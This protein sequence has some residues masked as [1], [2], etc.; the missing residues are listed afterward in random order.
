MNSRY[1]LKEH[2]MFDMEDSVMVIKYKDG[3]L[4]LENVA[5]LSDVSLQIWN[6]LKEG[7]MAQ[8][9]INHIAEPQRQRKKLHI[10]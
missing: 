6:F 4:D 7:M 9:I 2:E 3:V 1:M 5:Y 8:D 10:G